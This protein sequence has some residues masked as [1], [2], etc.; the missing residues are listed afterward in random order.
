MLLSEAVDLATSLDADAFAARFPDPLLLS[1][2]PI[3]VLEDGVTFATPSSGLEVAR[4]PD[5]REKLPGKGRSL[6]EET[7]KDVDPA[8]LL[9]MLSGAKT[10]PSMKALQ[11]KPAKASPHVIWI[12]KTNRNPFLMMVTVGRTGNNDIVLDDITVS[13]VH[14]YFVR[15]PGDRWMVHD[16]RSTN[17][18]FV[19]E[20]KVPVEGAPV[21]D[22]Q[23]VSF[24]SHHGFRFHTPRGFHA[25]V[26]KGETRKP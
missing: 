20:M 2:G 25:S 16:Q 11:D 5:R 22:G 14:A 1:L 10:V 3:E 12:T 15:H 7:W 8:T 18:T 9:A 19:G 23:R 6:F 4:P 13:K 17:G 24:G 26:R 21:G